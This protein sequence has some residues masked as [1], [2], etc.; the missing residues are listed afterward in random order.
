M[1]SI[2]LELSVVYAAAGTWI[3]HVDTGKKAHSVAID[4]LNKRIFPENA[5][6]ALSSTP[7]RE[8]RCVQS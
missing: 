5:Q 2:C 4:P 7:K 8:V 1:L 6:G 3:E